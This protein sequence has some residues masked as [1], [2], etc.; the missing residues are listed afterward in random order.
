MNRPSCPPCHGDCHQGRTC[1]AENHPA[2]ETWKKWYETITNDIK[3]SR[4]MFSRSSHGKAYRAG[5][6]AGIEEA[7]KVVKGGEEWKLWDTD[8]A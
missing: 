6:D 5:Y 4:F 2:Y 3:A 7:K 1:P 8:Q